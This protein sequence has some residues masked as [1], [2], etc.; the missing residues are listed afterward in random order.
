MHWLMEK[1][2]HI[3]PCILLCTSK[4]IL[5]NKVSSQRW[6]NTR[7]TTQ[8]IMPLNAY[9]SHAIIVDKQRHIPMPFEHILLCTSKM[10]K[11]LVKYTFL[12]IFGA[13]I[14]ILC[15]CTCT[16]HLNG[17]SVSFWLY[18]CLP[19]LSHAWFLCMTPRVFSLLVSTP[20][21]ELSQ[22]G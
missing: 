21:F 15:V 16:Q 5:K 6:I 8:Q 9:L 12:L 7:Q 3:C 18:C 22:N 11:Y 20:L 4:R 17:M 14:A 10:M 2:S 19:Q 1:P 13:C